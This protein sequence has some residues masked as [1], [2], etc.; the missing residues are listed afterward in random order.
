MKHMRMMWGCVAVIVVIAAAAITGADL[1]NWARLA[2]LAACPVMMITMMVMMTRRS[3]RDQP[4]VELDAADKG[5]GSTTRQSPP[6]AK[7]HA[8]QS[9]RRGE[10]S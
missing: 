8:G 9:P 7:P 3:D 2:V 1:P 5:V 10:R 6:G 4:A